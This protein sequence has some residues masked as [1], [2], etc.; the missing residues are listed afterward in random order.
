MA[1]AEV[2][3]AHWDGLLARLGVTDVYWSRGYVEASA[4]LAGGAP[5]LLHLPGAGGDVVFAAVVRANPVDV[6]TPYGYGGPLGVGEDPP[7]EAWAGAYDEWCAARGAVSSFVV[8]HPWL[9]GQDRPD[10]LRRTPMAGTVCWPLR[11][12]GLLAGMHSHHR[13]LVRRA[14]RAGLAASVRPAPEDLAAFTG[15]YEQTMRR[16]AAASFYLFGAE[17]WRA[18]QAGVPL[19]QVEV[20]DP[21]GEVVAGVLG[22]GRPPLLHYHLGAT[23]DAGRG[24]GAPQLALLALARWGREHGY[25]A[26]HLGGGVGGRDDELLRYKRRFAPEG[27]VPAAL[28]KAV[29]DPDAYR[30]LSGSPEIDWEGFFPAYRA[31]A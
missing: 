19:V 10:G 30:R 23:A 22:M 18:L 17:Y 21:E 1:L 20:R 29:H 8:L 2:D 3:A 13:R 14:E 7:L 9:A 11:R 31:R 5:L 4:P 28:G 26:L 25:E 6:V 12:G 16:N 27:L 15:L 24:S